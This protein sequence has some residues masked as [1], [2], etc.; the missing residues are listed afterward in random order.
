MIVFR[1]VL[2]KCPPQKVEDDVTQISEIKKT[3]N[4]YFE[5]LLWRDV[6]N[7]N[8][9]RWWGLFLAWHTQKL[10]KVTGNFT[11][12]STSYVITNIIR[13]KKQFRLTDFSTVKL[14]KVTFAKKRRTQNQ[15][16]WINHKW[17]W[18]DGIRVSV[19]VKILSA[20]DQKTDN[21][22]KFLIIDVDIT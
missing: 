19:K 21:S 22:L 18:A 17:D 20:T 9:D 15:F 14:K 7:W 6:S 3:E 5:K 12:E 4:W 2:E 13:D 11:K 8:F 1:F 16:W 10:T